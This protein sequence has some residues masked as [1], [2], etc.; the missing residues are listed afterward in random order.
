MKFVFLLSIVIAQTTKEAVQDLTNNAEF[1]RMYSKCNANARLTVRAAFHDFTSRSKMNRNEGGVDGSIQYELNVR[2]NAGLAPLVNQLLKFKSPSISF[3][4]ILAIGTVY[5]VRVCGVKVPIYYG[6]TDAT[7]AGPLKLVPSFSASFE[8]L[9]ARSADMGLSIDDMVSLIAGA[10]SIATTPQLGGG[11]LDSTIDRIDNVFAVQ[12]YTLKPTD[13][14]KILQSDVH[15]ASSQPG[16]RLFKMYASDEERMK[17]DFG[18]ALTK[19]LNLGWDNLA[20][21]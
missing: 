14:S 16:R 21:L 10:H 18:I 19:M 13:G 2:D 15:L 8:E 9:E 5:A 4:D 11:Q 12:M 3:A 7:K 20:F 6:R 1:T 17:K